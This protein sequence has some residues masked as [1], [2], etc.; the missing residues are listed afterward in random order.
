MV[1]KAYD[2]ENIKVQK[3]LESVRLRPGMFI[4]DTESGDGYHH[5]LNELIDNAVDEIVAGGCSEILVTLHSDGG[6]SVW[7]NGRGIPVD[8][9]AG[10]GR[11]ALEVIMTSLFSGAK[12]GDDVYTF[13]S[14]LHGVGLSVVNALSA[15]VRVRVRRDGKIYQQ[16]YEEGTPVS[17][18]R[19]VGTSTD[20]G[21]E[22]YFLPSRRYF[23]D[24]GANDFKEDI[25]RRRLRD[26]SFLIPPGVRL[27]LRDEKTGEETAFR[28]EL[29]LRGFI[30]LLS[31]GREPVTDKAF[32]FQ[33]V[34][35]GVRVGVALQWFRGGEHEEVLSFTNNLPQRDGGTHLTGLRVSVSGTLKNYMEREALMP[36][37]KEKFQITGEDMREGLVGVVAV[38]LANP[39]FS[40]QTKEKL[41]SQE[42]RLAVERLVGQHL[43][44]YLLENPAD[45]RRI[46]ARV[47]EA[48]R[49][50]EAM[51]RARDNE[52]Q[53]I[54]GEVASL[55]GKLADCQERDPRLCEIFLVE[56]DSAGGSAKQ[57]RDRRTQA[58][59]PLKGKILN[60]EKA[61]SEKMLSSQ[62]V[63]AL[64]TALG[65]GSTKNQDVDIDKLRYHRIII[66][67]D[68][69]VDGAHI[70]TLLLTLFY[71]R[72]RPLVEEGFVYIAQPPL[73]KIQHG[74]TA[75][76]LK[77]DGELEDYF[78]ENALRGSR[79]ETHHGTVWE[80]ETLAAAMRTQRRLDQTME[81]LSSR[82]EPE[83]L[84]AL[85][86]LALVG[87]G[88]SAGVRLDPAGLDAIL[89]AREKLARY[90][91]EADGDGLRVTRILHGVRS[92]YRYDR[93]ELDSEELR[94]LRQR[95]DK[96]RQL[97]VEGPFR[98]TRGE[99]NYE[100]ARME[101]VTR[102][103]LEVEAR[104]NTV[105]QRYKGLGEM[106]P[107][108]LA[109]T[110]MNPSTRRLLRVGI[111]DAVRAEEL[112]TTLMG[113]DVVPRRSF[114]EQNAVE[115][116]NLDV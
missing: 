20:T 56:G 22:V 73:Y 98:V 101:D 42:A 14:G 15:R 92:V 72:L 84:R 60:V 86:E 50:R 59:L 87:T 83:V 82:H 106:N 112:L 75:R 81:R 49:T 58:V 78:L 38:S 47:I 62:E 91:V 19:V 2:S 10:E 100:A 32:C 69:D 110:T 45:A 52:R 9:H 64:L 11:S 66:M 34:Y 44:E 16:D 55:P 40:S 23:R 51:R 97:D 109:E 93:S 8:Y 65:F 21:T 57:A 48:A 6:A 105:L 37:E 104:R 89:R 17:D 111:Q 96:V 3:G 31:T 13:S 103:L 67:T 54:G 79:V 53:R 43:E 74:K 27:V 26:L 1:S 108:Q 70:R 5:M 90:R 12:F 28:S 85:V 46:A 18:L 77:D 114:I 80:G 25:V 29:G 61:A 41:V 88:D 107:D 95:T 94:E 76:Y 102:W 36:K 63:V 24:N 68:A 115:V 113:E 99:R 39:L 33:S 7:D 71:R 116:V 30:D 4:G 35:E